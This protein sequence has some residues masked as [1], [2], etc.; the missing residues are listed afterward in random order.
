MKSSK[1]L[2]VIIV[3][4]AVLLFLMIVVSLF[5]AHYF[6]PIGGTPGKALKAE[7]SAKN[8]FYYDGQFHNPEDTYHSAP[9]H[10]E[11]KLEK[12]SKT[13]GAEHISELKRAEKANSNLHGSDILPRSF[14]L[15]IRIY[16]LILSSFR[17]AE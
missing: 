3:V 5:L 16:L 14:S 12:P 2:K 15:E 8:E 10:P 9:T 13:V 11:S 7:Y 6:K 17:A 4:F 1:A